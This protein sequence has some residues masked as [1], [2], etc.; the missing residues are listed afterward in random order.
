MPAQ[1]T[2]HFVQDLQQDIKIRQCGTIAFNK[3]NESN[4][5]SVDLYNGQEEY[6][7]G[8]SV[9]GACICPDGSTVPLT[10]SISGKTASVTLTGDCFAFPGQIGIG[11]QVVSGTTKTTVLKAIYN[12]EL[13]ETDDM[14][15]PG[16]RI[17][18]SVGQL[19]ADIEAATAEIPA[20]DMASLMSGIA[21]QFNTTTNYAAGAYVYYSGTLYRFT[22]DHAAGS[23]T[24]T[25]ATQVD[26]G[27]D[28]GSQVSN[29]KS[30]S[31]NN[32]DAFCVQDFS[33][34]L[35]FNAASSISPETGAN[36]NV[37]CRSGYNSYSR[38]TV[39]KCNLPE[40]NLTVWTYTT[41]SA[42]SGSY[43]PTGSN[44]V[45]GVT[46]VFIKPISGSNPNFRIGVVKKSGGGITAEERDAIAQNI[47]FYTLTDES[48]TK[49]G[50]PAD[51][52]AVGDSIEEIDVINGQLFE[53]NSIDVFEYG[54]AFK[55]GST[56]TSVGVTATRNADGSW[57]FNET[58]TQTT[59]FNLV[60]HVS[61]VPQYIIPGRSYKLCF[62]GSSIP[63]RVY[64]ELPDNVEEQ[65]DYGTD[66]VITIPQNLIGIVIRFQ[67]AN[68]S[69]FDNV[70][71]KPELVA[72][73]EFG[74]TGGGDVYNNT[75]NI[76]TTPQFTT[77]TNGW[78][79]AVDT[80]TSDETGKTDMTGAIM[81]MLTN[82]GYCHLSPGIFYVSGSI[83]MPTGSILEGCGRET[84]IRLLS[85]VTSGYIIKPTAYNQINN[86][87]FSGSRAT[88]TSFDPQIGTR[89]AI[90]FENEYGIVENSGATHCMVNNVWIENF[91]GAG[92]RCYRT[93]IGYARGLYVSQ[94]YINRCH[95]G[96]YIEKLSEFNRFVNVCIARGYDA[97]VNNSGNNMFH[98]CVFHANHAGFIMDNSIGTSGNNGH[99]SM[100]GCEFPHIGNSAGIAIYINGI[101]N[102]F[103]M[104]DC[105][106]GY[107]S[108]DVINSDGIMFNGFEFVRGV[109]DDQGVGHDA[110]ITVNGGGVVAFNN[111]MF[112]YDTQ[113]TPNITITNNNKVKFNNCYGATSGNAV[114]GN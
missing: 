20:S 58:A 97:C 39:I 66:A 10:G 82:T 114:T 19:V 85:S 48:L 44:Y 50:Y 43:S 61:D 98:S 5:I 96:I 109:D 70:T 104:A 89:H 105:Q 94:A 49:S 102:G 71:V 21:P 51:A 14:V 24:G 80:D 63:I 84:I 12:V 45:D 76:T 13:F 59:F 91:N 6:S 90:N 9:A 65:H 113:Y 34:T 23:W 32:M 4:I 75:Y 60:Q 40:Y 33:I 101:E 77:D 35:T 103:V 3:D 31:N 74:G 29:L 16:S 52:K 54:E 64:F 53:Y 42:S 46:S 72:V 17:T 86:I 38:P 112:M 1:F 73:N 8:G 92:I 11:I 68:G 47:S 36:A 26:L 107:C 30:V 28:L 79:Q 27:N 111:C 37:G 81:S 100:V 88:L 110:T 108:V 56:K 69:T 7:G 62:N 95:T 106:I 18:A 93:G 87:G 83:D 67:I 57:T 55:K 78:L 22:A 41:N 2:K 15:D 25:D 99:G